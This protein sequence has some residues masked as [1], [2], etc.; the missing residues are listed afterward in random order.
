M[1]LK[2]NS[3]ELVLLKDIIKPTNL[4]CHHNIFI[5]V[6]KMPSHASQG[7]GLSLSRFTYSWLFLF[8]SSFLCTSIAYRLLLLLGLKFCLKPN[9]EMV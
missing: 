1:S 4:L 6:N 8:F 7:R 9:S 3:T 5:N 2:D